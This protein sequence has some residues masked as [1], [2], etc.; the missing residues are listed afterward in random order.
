MK[1]LRVLIACEESQVVCRAFRAK[2]HEAYS[3]DIQECSGGH[4][5]WHIRGD[6]FEH[7]NKMRM[8][9][10]DLI[11]AHPDC[12]YIANSGVRWLYNDDGYFNH[13]RYRKMEDAC[14]FFNRF[15][16]WSRKVAIENPIPHKHAVAYIGKYNQLIQPWQFGHTTSKATC[17]W[18]KNLPPL[19]YTGIIPKEQRTQEIWR[20]APGPD[21][22]KNR[23]R[24]FQGI[25]NAM[26]NQW[27]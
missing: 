15:K 21:R 19:I 11:I 8:K 22:K 23:S 12:T 17:L 10:Y 27:G 4:P 3:C 13:T 16:Y 14:H 6:V 2:G 24:T 20:M 26:A 18:L 25:A 7:L 5:E 1:K 9:Y